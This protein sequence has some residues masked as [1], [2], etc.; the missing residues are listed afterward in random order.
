MRSVFG[1]IV[2]IKRYSL[3]S[4]F[5]V[6]HKTIV[7]VHAYHFWAQ[8]SSD[9]RYTYLSF[10]LRMETLTFPR[11][12]FKYSP[13]CLGKDCSISC[14]W[15]IRRNKS[16]SN[17]RTASC[18]A[19]FVPIFL[20]NLTQR[21]SLLTLHKIN[22][23]NTLNKSDVSSRNNLMHSSYVLME[24]LIIP[25]RYLWWLIPFIHFAW[26]SPTSSNLLIYSRFN[27]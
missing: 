4:E 25:R 16:F 15:A 21:K 6:T 3:F 23:L 17:P 22:N 1:S 14:N 5:S 11:I 9:H 27:S 12:I 26:S 8:F 13:F 19:S 7:E 18:F 2:L 24:R 10:L 20:D